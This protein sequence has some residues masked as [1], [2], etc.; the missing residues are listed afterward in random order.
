MSH[1]F[2]Q[3]EQSGSSSTATSSPSRKRRLPDDWVDAEAGPFNLIERSRGGFSAQ[4]EKG[5]GEERQRRTE[6]SFG[7]RGAGVQGAQSRS[8]GSYQ[9]SHRDGPSR[10]SQQTIGRPLSLL[11]N[12]SPAATTPLPQ[13]PTRPAT[14]SSAAQR[15]ASAPYPS[16]SS[17]AAG[18]F[19]RHKDSPSIGRSLVKKRGP[20]PD[21]VLFGE[22]PSPVK[23]PPPPQI[24]LPRLEQ[25][26][27]YESLFTPS[28]KPSEITVWPKQIYSKPSVPQTLIPSNN[29]RPVQHFYKPTVLGAVESRQDA[30]KGKE[31]RRE[32]AVEPTSPRNRTIRRKEEHAEL[33]ARDRMRNKDECGSQALQQR[34]WPAEGGRSLRRRSTTSAQTSDAIGSVP[35]S[36]RKK[37]ERVKGKAREE[38]EWIELLEIDGGQKVEV[39]KDWQPPPQPWMRDYPED[40]LDDCIHPKSLDVVLDTVVVASTDIPAL[41]RIAGEGLVHVD[42]ELSGLHSSSDLRN[43][44]VIAS[45]SLDEQKFVLR[46]LS[47][48]G[49]PAGEG[50]TTLH[51]DSSNTITGP[52]SLF[53]DPQVVR[54]AG[55]S[56]LSLSV[57]IGFGAACFSST[58]SIAA[59]TPCGKLIPRAMSGF[60]PFAGQ[61]DLRT[62]ISVSIDVIPVRKTVLTAEEAKLEIERRVERLS[63]EAEGGVWVPDAQAIRA[64]QWKEHE[65]RMPDLGEGRMGYDFLTKLPYNAG[66]VLRNFNADTP[67]TTRS[68]VRAFD[69]KLSRTSLTLQ[70]KLLAR[71]HGRWCHVNPFFPS[72]YERELACWTHYAPLVHHFGL[73]FELAMHLLTRQVRHHL[74]AEHELRLVLHQ[75]DEEAVRIEAG[76][77]KGYEQLRREALWVEAGKASREGTDARAAG[78]G[79]GRDV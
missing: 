6:G 56:D 27:E 5:K 57:K 75:Y 70:E 68:A 17:N 28:K 24:N 23:Q 39:P 52:S 62:G 71:A 9:Q 13:L 51:R 50:Y 53:I 10:G 2:P 15:T 46:D 42:L 67:E 41:V 35:G 16:T 7:G 45:R 63:L 78:R 79:E 3:S 25:T 1:Y 69:E 58:L 37:K 44:L 73:R 26:K 64:E 32:K 11:P 36:A 18:L 49:E 72:V 77:R 43:S 4:M 33:R 8:S 38:P 22:A 48:A 74:L 66:E 19:S 31:T 47:E 55:M 30:G 29:F 60:F 40:S 59:S 61:K 12:P 54:L 65:L 34:E 20:A 14:S 76:K 21:D